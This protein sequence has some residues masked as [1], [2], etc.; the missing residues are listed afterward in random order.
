[1]IPS[2]YQIRAEFR[3]FNY[4]NCIVHIV[5]SYFSGIVAHFY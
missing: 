1:M 4:R 5:E 2:Y 3:Y